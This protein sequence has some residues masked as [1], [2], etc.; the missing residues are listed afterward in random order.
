MSKRTNEANMPYK[1]KQQSPEHSA[2]LFYDHAEHWGVVDNVWKK[3]PLHYSAE[4][5]ADCK[6]GSGKKYRKCCGK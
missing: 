6:C 1:V 5:N 4:A 2:H 3:T